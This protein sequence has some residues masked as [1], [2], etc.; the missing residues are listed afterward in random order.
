MR[1]VKG[2]VIQVK[3][4]N[5]ILIT[6]QG[7]FLESRLTETPPRVGEEI[8]VIPEEKAKPRTKK[9]FSLAL[10]AA[11]AIFILGQS[12]LTALAQPAFYLH[13]DINPSVELELSRELRVTGARALNSDG[14]KLLMRAD[15]ENL[16]ASE[17]LQKIIDT[18]IFLDYLAP[19]RE[20]TV[21][22]SIVKN[23]NLESYDEESLAEELQQGI[24]ARLQE[25]NLEGVVGIAT[26][27]RKL[28]KLA[29]Q[30]GRS[31]NSLLLEE[32]DGTGDKTAATPIKSKLNK[33][34]SKIYRLSTIKPQNKGENISNV[35]PPQA[36]P[37]EIIEKSKN[38]DNWEKGPS[39]PGDAD[40]TVQGKGPK[41]Q[42]GTKQPETPGSPT[43]P[44]QAPDNGAGAPQGR[45][46]GPR[47]KYP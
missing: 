29:A 13:V 25:S 8:S 5:I 28:R 32:N 47:H 10:A 12:I 19:G 27:E 34:L 36:G 38:P 15:V 21:L 18:A 41:G 42:A 43:K 3:D 31:I 24:T 26:A 23:K 44:S 17:A 2:R 6:P 14:Q 16:P 33:R 7:E 4:N 22:V 39:T 46:K 20:N 37:K 45:E 9:M 30:K 40:T 35:K 1:R 11:I